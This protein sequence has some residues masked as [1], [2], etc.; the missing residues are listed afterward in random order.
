MR[1]KIILSILAILI[2]ILTLIGVSYSYYSAKVK[3][4]EETQTVIKANELNLIFTGTS[5][6]NAENIIPGD[7]FTK[8]F[9]VE[10]TSNKA[11]TYNIYLENI[12]NEFNE[13]LV[14]TLSDEDKTVIEEEVLP[15]TNDNKNYLITDISID[16]KEI[17]TY[18]MKVEF[19][20]SDKNQN[21]NQN[22][23]FKAT[24]GIDTNRIEQDKVSVWT[25][26]NDENGNGI[27]DIG[28][29]LTVGSETFYVINNDGTNIKMISKY[30]VDPVTNVQSEIATGINHNYVRTYEDSNA[31]VY[32]NNYANTLASL[33]AN[34]INITS[35][36]IDE[37]ISLGCSS[38]PSYNC[39]TSTYK[40][41][42]STSYYTSTAGQTGEDLVIINKYTGSIIRD[43]SQSDDGYETKYGVRPVI[44]INADEL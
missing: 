41:I 33:N 18:T 6:I 4:I 20:Y 26:S 11:V 13:D 24:L 16:S 37:L 14:Y 29:E 39:T 25:L 44:T 34:I 40:W 35:I 17:K 8:T 2:I 15:S 27:A 3:K 21:T 5:E 43:L 1:R 36:T 19:K 38:D 28:D 23:E 42:Y 32:V 31:Y 9:T 12:T 7:S 30:N 22:K 10:N